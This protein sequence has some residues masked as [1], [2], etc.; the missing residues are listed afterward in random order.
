MGRNSG[1]IRNTR[2]GTAPKLSDLAKDAIDYYIS[3]NGYDMAF[4]LRNGTPLSDEDKLLVQGLDEATAHPLDSSLTVY[5]GA[6]IESIFGS[7]AGEK[8]GWLKS[9]IV[10][11]YKTQESQAIYD[12]II[13]KGLKSSHTDK[14]F[15]SSSIHNS[16]AEGFG[17]EHPVVMKI[18]VPKGTRGIE[19]HKQKDIYKN[20][21]SEKEVLL[22]R[23]LS[24]RVSRVYSK[25]GYIYIDAIIKK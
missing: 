15:M 10:G 8:F 11:G 14:S 17:G 18:T 13:Q 7:E 19:L 4:G 3:G 25:N 20:N 24:Y 6:S 9:H 5:R 2:L 1:G 12:S 21:T 23:N 16:V 22:S